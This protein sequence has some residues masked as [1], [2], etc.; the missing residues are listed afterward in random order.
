VGFGAAVVQRAGFSPV[1]ILSLLLGAAV[2]AA[3]AGAAAVLRVRGRR[4]LT[5]GALLG[6]S[7]LIFSQ[8]IALHRMCIAPWEHR[9]L[10]QPELA[11]FR[12]PPPR[13]IEHMRRESEGG[14][15]WLWLLDAV[16]VAGT[17]TW[18]VAYGA[19]TSARLRLAGDQATIV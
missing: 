8:H 16:L 9:Q 1:V 19:K 3:A 2:G 15:W 6:S 17:A 4:L 5:L 14:R 7:V 18:T 13:F 10:E 12:D 11:L